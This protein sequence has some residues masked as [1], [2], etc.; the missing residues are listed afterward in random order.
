MPGRHSDL[1]HNGQASWL[2]L[3]YLNNF[4]KDKEAVVLIVGM[5][6]K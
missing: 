4:E 2:P 1:G 6:V 5:L 3:W